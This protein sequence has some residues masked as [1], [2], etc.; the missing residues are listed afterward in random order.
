MKPTGDQ[1][2][3][4][5]SV[6]DGDLW[7]QL[8]EADTAERFCFSWLGLQARMIGGVTGAL[9]VL[10]RPGR[11]TLFPVAMWPGDFREPTRFRGI[12]ERALREAK[13]V[14]LRNDAEGELASPEDLRFDVA[15][16]VRLEGAQVRGVAVFEMKS[17]SQIELQS[18]LRQLQWGTAWLQKWVL[19]Q[20][21]GPGAEVRDRLTAALEMTA[22]ALEAEKF[23]GAALAC[24][25]NLATRLECDRV[26][27]GFLKRN[28]VKVHALSHSAQFG[29]R[30]NLIRTIA[31]A[32]GESMDQKAV[33]HYPD[34]TD[35]GVQI[36]HSHEQLAR[37]H[38]DRVVLTIPFLAAEGRAYGALTFERSAP[39][40]FD[41]ETVELCE[42]VAA[43]VGPI[44]EE[45][46]LNDRLVI[47]KL[48]ESLWNQVKKLIGP[49]H[50]VRKLVAGTA[51]LLVIFFSVYTSPF[52][53]TAK[54]TL[55]GEVQRAVTAP[56]RSFIAEAP[57]RGGDIV[58]E[59][60][61]LCTLDDKDLRLEH[62][63]W[64]HEREQY[65]LEH[66]KAMAEGDLALMKVLGKRVNQADAQL[67]LLDDQISRT[68]ILAPF[69]GLVVSGDL[70]QSLGAPVETGQ[71]LFQVAPL[72]AYRVMLQV[73][74]KD[75]RHVSVDQVGELILTSMPE[76]KLSFT[77]SKITPIS[78][79]EEGRSYYLVEAALEQVSQRLR[80]GMEGFGKIE[81]DR[82]KLIW[83]WT[84]K[85]VDW[86]RLWAWSWLP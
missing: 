28:Q 31:L 52:R 55:E 9:V 69:A 16:P 66:R 47:V 63:R 4:G 18:A 22:A 1:E 30:M 10:K 62:A 53:V 57:R 64:S 32:M 54:M 38:G 19:Q 20:D 73:D 6:S 42:G 68:R 35:K 71:V 36:L 14:V 65:V 58:A 83:I 86:V 13:G 39:E 45:K 17:R 50:T 56:F 82:R 78:V 61:L 79:S 74:E 49:R 40:P 81:I 23:Q 60:D 70:S 29:K 44:L 8:A 46:R 84:H 59:G 15:Y 21:A 67:S 3:P 37:A 80:P 26:S 11:S 51:L 7:R 48:A 25:T 43:M 2:L 75:I 41:R 12:I 34:P 24:V 76:E 5:G 77:V 72:D 85:L 33:L 27:A